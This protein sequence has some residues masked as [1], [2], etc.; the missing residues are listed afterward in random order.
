[1]PLIGQDQSLKSLTKA[2]KSLLSNKMNL[3]AKIII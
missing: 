2:V 3:T 1:M